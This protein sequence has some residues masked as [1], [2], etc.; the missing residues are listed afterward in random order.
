[1][2]AEDLAKKFITRSFPKESQ[3]SNLKASKYFN[4]SSNDNNNNTMH[5]TNQSELTIKD[6]LYN[7]DD[8]NNSNI[9]TYNTTETP[10]T[11]NNPSN[12]NTT[13]HRKTRSRKI[14]LDKSLYSNNSIKVNLKINFNNNKISKKRI[15]EDD[16]IIPEDFRD[17][18]ICN[19]TPIIN[20]NNYI[21]DTINILPDN[22]HIEGFSSEEENYI[23]DNNLNKSINNTKINSNSKNNH[24]NNPISKNLDL[25]LE[26][27]T[28]DFNWRKSN[29]NNVN[30]GNPN[31]NSNTNITNNEKLN[32]SDTNILRNIWNCSNYNNYNNNNNNIQ[33]LSIEAFSIV[34]IEEKIN[35]IMNMSTNT[36]N[37]NNSYSSNN[38][39]SMKCSNMYNIIYPFK[40]DVLLSMKNNTNTN[41]INNSKDF[42]LLHELFTIN[43][44]YMYI[45]LVLVLY[46]EYNEFISS[47]FYNNNSNSNSSNNFS[48]NSNTNNTT[49]EKSLKNCAF[50]IRQNL[51]IYVYVNNGDNT[52]NINTNSN[53]S[54]SNLLEEANMWLNNNLYEDNNMN[55][56]SNFNT[57]KK[58]LSNNNKIVYS[59]LKN[60][61]RN[62]SS[63]AN[64]VGVKP[65]LDLLTIYLEEIHNSTSSTCNNSNNSSSNTLSKLDNIKNNILF[66]FYD[67]SLEYLNK[68]DNNTNTNNN[69]NNKNNDNDRKKI[70]E[71]NNTNIN[72]NTNNIVNNTNTNN[73]ENITIE[74]D[75]NNIN[76]NNQDS[77]TINQTNPEDQKPTP[78]YLPIFNPYINNNIN[79]HNSNIY[80]LIE[81]TLVLDLDETLVHYVEESDQAFIQIRP[82]AELFV[83]ELSKFYELVIF[84][85]AMQ[86]YADLVLDQLDPNN[87]ISY[88]LYRQHTNKSKGVHI[89]D[90]SLLNRDLKKTCIVDNVEDNFQ[91]QPSNG[92][93]IKNFEGEED[94]NELEYLVEKLKGIVITKN[95][96]K[97]HMNGDRDYSS[98]LDSNS[99]QN[100]E[101]YFLE[102]VKEIQKNMKERY[103]G[104]GNSNV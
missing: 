21:L 97:Y 61:I 18:N 92:L 16:D 58:Y 41:Y 50:N 94:D 60:V 4:N 85:A 72:N 82:G 91:L 88:R 77:T 48:Y 70:E 19:I 87:Y 104:V 22:H 96:V 71:Y 76:N 8:S 75:Q 26:Y 9:N 99:K 57:A 89:K 55:S 67:E 29:K 46:K 2:N 101:E 3:I 38:N 66:S 90:L 79:I 95:E 32:S 62:I 37:N 15:E 30:S 49:I 100:N 11:I 7:H 51:L 45:L 56:N 35:G 14:I 59:I 98:M 73:I 64:E 44:S 53:S 54:L 42:L 6:S 5:N 36:P 93:N 80:N 10:N 74:D 52:N 43:F 47:T 63:N 68:L 31:N 23:S 24:K 81:Y 78:P 1:M 86:D 69:N 84:T 83:E 12:S 28:I 20:S 33:I 39:S 13:K 40:D 34:L 65:N 17:D 102:C 27:N 25:D 103:S